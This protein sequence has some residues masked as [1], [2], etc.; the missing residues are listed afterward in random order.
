MTILQASQLP[1]PS[2][3][4]LEKQFYGFSYGF[5]TQL[6]KILDSF[7]LIESPLHHA[8]LLQRICRPSWLVVYSPDGEGESFRQQMV[9]VL[10]ALNADVVLLSQ[11]ERNSEIAAGLRN[12][13]K[14]SH[15]SRGRD[16]QTWHYKVAYHPEFFHFDREGYSGWSEMRHLRP[17]EVDSV[18]LALA[19]SFYQERVQP[20]LFA[21]T[22]KY[23][24][25]EAQ[26][27]AAE[28]F[29]FVP[30]QLPDDSVASLTLSGSYLETMAAAIRRLLR[31]GQ[32]VVVK[33]HPLCRHDGIST[34]LH[35]A[36][37]DGAIISDASIHAILP[38]ARAVVTFNSGVGFEALLYQKP[39]ICLGQ[40]DYAIAG[41]EVR[42]IDDLDAILQA[43]LT[44]KS[45]GFIRKFLFLAMRKFQVDLTSRSNVIQHVLRTL[46][47]NYLDGTRP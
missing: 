13:I 40:A 7:F 20:I 28:D 5:Y 34:L 38:A 25:G 24:Q 16:H 17:A 35:E 43:A 32:R 26:P 33:R 6:E 15:H 11:S 36:R 37:A 39:V 1:L 30:L 12:R 10:Q 45:S 46:S 4:D 18:P 47:W 9:S 21:K 2:A 41:W 19:D 14:L 22:S 3:A 27:L 29:V 23:P 42:Q 31:Q 44:G 8:R